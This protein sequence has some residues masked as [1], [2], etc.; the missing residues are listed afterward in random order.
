MTFRTL[1]MMTRSCSLYKYVCACVCGG[2]N[3][4]FN[5]PRSGNLP[6]LK[7]IDEVVISLRQLQRGA[8]FSVKDHARKLKLLQDQTSRRK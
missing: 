4:N 5:P 7:A 2:S 6:N 8:N 3:V 1:A